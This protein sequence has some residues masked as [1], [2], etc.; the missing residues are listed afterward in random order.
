[1]IQAESSF[2]RRDSLGWWYWNRFDYFKAFRT[3]WDFWV[4]LW[5]SENGVIFGVLSTRMKIDIYHQTY[6]VYRLV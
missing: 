2:F 6:R 5:G 1:M 4:V 3:V